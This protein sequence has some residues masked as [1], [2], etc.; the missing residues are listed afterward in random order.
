MF[1]INMRHLFSYRLSEIFYM[2]LFWQLRNLPLISEKF[3]VS[4]EIS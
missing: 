1:L 3:F 2:Q 4:N